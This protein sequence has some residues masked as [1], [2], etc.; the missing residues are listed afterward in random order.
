MSLHHARVIHGSLPNRSRQRRVGFALQAFVA[1]GGRQSVG[2]NYWLAARG[3]C[4]HG[5][6]NWLRR[7]DGD[8]DAAAIA[9]REKANRN[10]AEILYQ[11]ARQ[12]RAY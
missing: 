7:P 3:K 5:D 10:W 6:V 1:S 11:G 8:M 2:E 12:R 9:E 4:N